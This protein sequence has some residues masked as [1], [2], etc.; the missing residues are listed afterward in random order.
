MQKKYSQLIISILCDVVGMLSY[1]VP[2]IGEFS[3]LVWAPLSAFIIYNLYNGK[4]AK[5]AA[6]VSFLEEILPIDLIPTFTFTWLYTHY[7]KKRVED[8]KK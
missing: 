2:A 5:V 8:S 3:D 4:E 1:F 7:I 6:A